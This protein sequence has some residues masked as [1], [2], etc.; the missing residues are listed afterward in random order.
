MGGETPPL[1]HFQGPPGSFMGRLKSQFWPQ[2]AKIKI[3]PLS[4]INLVRLGAMR[5]KEVATCW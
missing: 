5:D 2:R 4:S 3:H 1:C